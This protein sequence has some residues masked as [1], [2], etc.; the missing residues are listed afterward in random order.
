MIACLTAASL[1][2]FAASDATATI[3]TKTNARI[4]RMVDPPAQ[5]LAINQL[6]TLTAT[7]L[8]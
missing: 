6:G 1:C 8:A 3:I 5:S 2:A 7:M 4:V